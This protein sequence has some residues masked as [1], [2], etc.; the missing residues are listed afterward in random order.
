MSHSPVPLFTLRPLCPDDEYGLTEL[1]ARPDV[2]ERMGT[3]TGSTHSAS[4]GIRAIISNLEFVGV[5]GF[6]KSGAY[7][8]TCIELICAIRSAFER[9]GFARAASERL[10]A[11]ETITVGRRLLAS[12]R[13]DNLSGQRLA[14][15]LGFR[16]TGDSRACGDAIWELTASR[17]H[18]PAI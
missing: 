13:E 17:V 2:R 9:K 1:N 11:A 14:S 18:A 6:V 15:H 5:V 10:I 8:G 3:L 7:D 16:P 12:V 4:L